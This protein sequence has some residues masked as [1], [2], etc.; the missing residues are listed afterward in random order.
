MWTGGNQ[1][2]QRVCEVSDTVP[3][4]PGSAA[5]VVRPVARRSTIDTCRTLSIWIVSLSLGWEH[6]SWPFSVL[7]ITGFA[8]LVY[9]RCSL[10]MVPAD[11]VRAVTEHLSSMVSCDQSYSRQIHPN[12]HI[13]RMKKYLIPQ[14]SCQQH[15]GKAEL[16]TMLYRSTKRIIVLDNQ[17]A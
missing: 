8:L 13:F 15:K 12:C 17:V 5:D 9:V 6:L 10:V 11:L 1:G 2:R 16:D 14:R 4:I 7:Q 3:V